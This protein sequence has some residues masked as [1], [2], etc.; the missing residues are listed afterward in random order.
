MTQFL[1]TPAAAACL[2]SRYGFGSISTLNKLRCVGGGPRFR[3]VGDKIV[4]YEAADLDDWAEAKLGPRQRSTSDALQRVAKSNVHCEP[5][6]SEA[7]P[8]HPEDGVREADPNRP[9]RHPTSATGPRRAAGR[10]TE[11]AS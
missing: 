4:V 9:A 8:R 1:R 6:P 2:R 11:L 5:T 3:K 7:P 10:R